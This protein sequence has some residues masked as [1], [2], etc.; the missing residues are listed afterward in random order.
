MTV[1]AV[2][3]GLV[4]GVALASLGY[5]NDTW[6][7]FSYI[8]GD[9][10]PA[11]AFGLLLI[12]LLLVNPLLRLIGRWQFA[13]GE[14]VTILALMM[15]GSVLAGSGLFWT[16]PHPIIT[17][18]SDQAN[19]PGWQAKDL[20]QYVPPRMLVADVYRDYA[21]AH[22][23]TRQ[24]DEKTMRAALAR[25]LAQEQISPAEAQRSLDELDDLAKRPRGDLIFELY[26]RQNAAAVEAL[27]GQTWEKAVAASLGR[28]SET[29]RNLL[30]QAPSTAQATTQQARLKLRDLAR[31]YLSEQKIA[32]S[33]GDAPELA[34]AIHLGR[35]TETFGKL[36]AESRQPMGELAYAEYVSRHKLAPSPGQPPR[37]VIA[38]HLAK[39]RL[40]GSEADDILRGLDSEYDRI[41]RGYMNGLSRPKQLL[42][43]GQVPWE[44]WRP[45]LTFWYAVLSLVFIGGIAAAVVVHR[46]WSQREHLAYP[47]VIFANELISDGSTGLVNPIFRNR[48][49]WIGF[50]IA[51]LVLVVNGYQRY[52]KEFLTIPIGVSFNPFRDLLGPIMKV[53]MY[54]QNI[55]NVS[56]YFSAIGL[57]YF[58]TSEASFSLGI[59]GWMYVL[60]AAPLVQAGV[61]MSVSTYSG[62]LPMYMYFGAYLG[63]AVIV[64]YL[65]RRFYAAVLSRSVGLRWG[66]DVLPRE[67][68]ACRIT[69][70]AAAALA[71]LLVSIGLHWLIAIL[72]VAL[73]G[74]VFLMIGRVNVATGLFV[75][76]PMWHPVDILLGIFGA[77]ALGPHVLIILGVLCTVVTFDS[78]ITSLPLVLNALKLGE[79]QKVKT[80]RLAGWMGVGIV[81]ALVISVPLTVWL[82]YDLG[83]SGVQSGGTAWGLTVARYPFTMLERNINQLASSDQLTAAALPTDFW[84][85]MHMRPAAHFWT[86]MGIGMGL[87]L[88]CSW[89][90]LRFSGWPLHPLVFLVWGTPW[91]TAYAP[92]FLLAWLLKNAITRYGGQKSYFRA[93]PLFIGLVAGEFAAAIL[94]AI[95]GV[96]YY[97]YTGTPGQSFLVRP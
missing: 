68:W 40:T 2:L 80:G 94:W 6:M 73:C 21:R 81:L 47:T 25:H 50:G 30:R 32:G 70:M 79:L 22:G 56:L 42:P 26:A 90:R 33:E 88:A 76:Q 18:I 43:I 49:F 77:Y 10:V 37:Q 53:P 45:A 36:Q 59:S 93:R 13:G 39:G 62:G 78:R 75:I 15:M 64:L 38:D 8:G 3:I 97:L 28:D 63:M 24:G 1:R 89:L 29:Y 17:P 31:Q 48:M 35:Q 12:G 86:A 65:G 58:L 52:N 11:H 74:L 4:I 95:V 87:V 85:L 27:V 44:A 72:F 96:V 84:R 66:D 7:F 46:Q 91:M 61:D 41:I 23:I 14:W 57:A 55:L 83:V 20:L 69:I 54:G 5:I 92:S 34:L 71:W 82:L 67:V 9:L 51:M 60:A 16:F 19:S